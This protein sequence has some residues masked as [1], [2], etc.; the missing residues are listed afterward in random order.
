M[1]IAQ[2]NT[3]CKKGSVGR[4]A[5]DLYTLTRERGDEAV[6]I[7][8]R[9]S[10]P[11]GVKGYKTGNPL[12]MGVHVLLNFFRDKSGFGSGR[13]TGKLLA[14]LDQERPDIVHLHNI[15]GFYLQVELLFAYLKSRKIPVVWTLHDC[16]PFTGHCAYYDYVNCKGFRE[17]CKKCVHHAKLYPYALFKDDAAVNFIRKREAFQGVGRMV[18]ATPSDWLAGQVRQSFLGD[19]ETRVIPNGIDLEIFHD[20]SRDRVSK[21][22]LDILGVANIWEARKGLDYLEQLAERM[23]EGWRLTV[24]GVS[25]GQKRK[26]EKKFPG[27]RVRALM[28][29]ESMQELAE[30]YRRA[31]VFVNPTLEDNF[32]TTNLEALACGTPV[33]TFRTGG[34]GEMLNGDCGVVIRDRSVGGL[35]RGIR[36][37]CGLNRMDCRKQA[38]LY[39]KTDRLGEYLDLYRSLTEDGNGSI[40]I[41]YN[42]HV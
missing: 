7:Y 24:I 34:S 37:A 28:R 16:W 23:P 40:G 31:D 27:E 12:D 17:G 14:Y 15:H 3:V 21:S 35:I 20:D 26:L 33:V 10:A 13:A 41:H 1:K 25:A 32:P 2:I 38:V 36:I 8:G 4:I 5:L 6:F 18:L 42:D 9:G 11:A 19:Y 39:D 29:T 30:Y 22:G